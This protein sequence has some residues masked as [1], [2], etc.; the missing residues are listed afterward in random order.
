MWVRRVC[1]IPLLLVLGSGCAMY[2]TATRNLFEAVV[3]SADDCAALRRNRKLADE[4]WKEVV[5]GNPGVAYSPDYA[6]GFKDGYAGTLEEGGKPVPPT[7]PP[8]RY[9]RP[10]FQTPAGYQ[11]IE[12]WYAGFNHGTAAAVAWVPPYLK[13][14]PSSG[15][16]LKGSRSRSRPPNPAGEIP[17]EPAEELPPPK[18]QTPPSGGRDKAEPARRERGPV[19]AGIIGPEAR[20]A[21]RAGTFPHFRP[22]EWEDKAHPQARVNEAARQPARG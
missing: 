2:T 20:A 5:V 19:K 18:R 10:K 6:H 21:G 17:P 15:V 7:V 11:A 22:W 9:R 12:D 4:A 16:E 3:D 13:T 1:L 14:L 8:W